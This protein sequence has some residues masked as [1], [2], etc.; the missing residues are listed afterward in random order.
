MVLLPHTR[1]SQTLLL[2]SP[3]KKSY[4][5][6]LSYRK[7]QREDKS[8]GK[9]WAWRVASAPQNTS[10]TR[11][12]DKLVNVASVKPSPPASAA[13]S[14]SFPASSTPEDARLGRTSCL[15][16]K[17]CRKESANV[18]KPEETGL[19][20][21][22]ARLESLSNRIEVR[23][24]Q[25][26]KSAENN[27]SVW[28]RRIRYSFLHPLNCWT[29]YLIHSEV[30]SITTLFDKDGIIATKNSIYSYQPL[31]T[32]RNTE[33]QKGQILHFR[34]QKNCSWEEHLLLYTTKFADCHQIVLAK[35]TPMSAL[36]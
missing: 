1:F 5:M 26:H 16:I 17:S 6:S 21:I 12:I 30:N 2:Q 35:H 22:T 24:F 9:S 8:V 34:E 23:K 3:I 4:Q 18:T 19:T 31:W 36:C 28:K 10:L 13:A 20:W 14:S 29:E 15:F 11:I 27:F 25:C 33:T 7:F 32:N